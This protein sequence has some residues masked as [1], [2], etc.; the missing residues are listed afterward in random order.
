[1]FVALAR[2]AILCA[3]AICA[4]SAPSLAQS[5]FDGPYLGAGVGWDRLNAD[6]KYT[7]FE[8]GVPVSTFN[9]NRAGNGVQGEF[10]AGYGRTWGNFYASGEA[11][12]GISSASAAI[13]NAFAVGGDAYTINIRVR[14]RWSAT[15]SVRGGYLLTPN[16]LAFTRFGWAFADARISYTATETSAAGTRFFSGRTSQWINGPRVGAGFEWALLPYLHLR[17]DWTYTW[18]NRISVTGTVAPPPAA[19]VVVNDSRTKPR[20]SL[21]LF[22]L[23]YQFG[24]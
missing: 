16:L 2:P 15:P 7:L 10:F 13:D 22:S 24:L 23:V 3:A 1:M 18:Y 11:G 5:P 20:Q 12:F 9:F 17:G 6:G 4:L 19:D 8:N 21:L 14:E